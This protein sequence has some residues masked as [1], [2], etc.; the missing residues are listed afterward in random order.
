MISNVAIRDETVADIAEITAVTVKAFSSL[1]IS[2][3]TEQFVISALR[4]ARVL[5]LSLVAE[6][7]GEI[8]GHIAFSPVH[9]SDGSLSWYGLGPV[10]V[11][12]D[13][14][15]RGIG[16]A[17]VQEGLERLK[18]MQAKGCCVVGHPEYYP[19]FGFEH[20]PGLLVEGVPPEAFFAL[21]FDGRAPQG[22]VTFHEAFNATC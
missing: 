17:L 12:P 18:L 21:P 20:I 9:I 8:I 15:K 11:L 6:L 1:D 14:Q 16:G 7:H 19:K 5:T 4:N 10:S 2:N 22:T 13:Y 3:H